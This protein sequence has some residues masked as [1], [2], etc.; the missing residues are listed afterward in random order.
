MIHWIVKLHPHIGAL[1]MIPMALITLFVMAFFVIFFLDTWSAYS[2]RPNSEEEW[3][4]KEKDFH[5]NHAQDTFK[6]TNVRENP[7]AF[8]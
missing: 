1:F 4:E 6:R 2:L 8:K 3:K 5:I 7:K